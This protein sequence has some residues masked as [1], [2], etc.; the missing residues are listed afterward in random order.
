MPPGT[1]VVRVTVNPPFVA[2]SGEAC[3]H[4]DTLNLCHQLP[5]SNYAN[6][7]GEATITIPAHPGRA[8]V[9]PMA[10][11]APVKEVQGH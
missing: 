8:G 1:Y 2:A 10:G 9:G 7:I 5:E 6:N 3:P 4:K 11:T